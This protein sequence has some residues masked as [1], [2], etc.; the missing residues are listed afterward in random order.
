[1]K[2]GSLHTQTA[3]GFCFVSG[4]QLKKIRK[5]KSGTGCK[6]IVSTLIW[7]PIHA[8]CGDLIFSDF[9]SRGLEFWSF[10]RSQKDIKVLKAKPLGVCTPFGPEMGFLKGRAYVLRSD[11]LKI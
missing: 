2:A 3:Q 4:C 1:M 11:I 9:F 7:R 6:S 5:F 10:F 8:G